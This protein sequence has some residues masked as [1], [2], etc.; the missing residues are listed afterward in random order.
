MSLLDRIHAN[1]C[2]VRD[3]ARAKAPDADLCRDDLTE[4]WHHRLNREDDGTYTRRRT[5][6]LR[7]E[8]PV[9]A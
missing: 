3:C 7:V 8:W 6:P 2:A 1:K 9:A 4:L 5:F